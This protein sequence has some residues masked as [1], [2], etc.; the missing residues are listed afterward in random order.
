[1]TRSAVAA[2]T[3]YRAPMRRRFGWLL[4]G[5]LLAAMVGACAADP[6]SPHPSP[7]IT[8]QLPPTVTVIGAAGQESVIPI[9]LTCDS[10]IAALDAALAGAPQPVLS[11]QFGYG[12]Y[13]PPGRRC[14]PF[15]ATSVNQGYVV[16]TFDG[17]PTQV[18]NVG[19]DAS[20]QTILLNIE[21]APPTT[22]FTR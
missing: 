7:A 20:G 1:M 15:L 18:A 21:L 8:C 9:A 12:R 6:P 14:G 11:L 4:G 3:A 17:A 19:T 5:A 10:A 13:C 2:P 16:V 22:T